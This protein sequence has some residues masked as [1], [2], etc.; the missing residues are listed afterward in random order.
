V[1]DPA[2]GQQAFGQRTSNALGGAG[3]ESS[4]HF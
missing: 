1:D 3:D 2:V 4:G